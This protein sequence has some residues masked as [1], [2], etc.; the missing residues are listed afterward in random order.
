M[1]VHKE[2]HYFGSDLASPYRVDAKEYLQCFGTWR[3][4]KIAGETSV[5]Y[6]SSTEAA[7]EIRNFNPDG[8]VIIMLR[9]PV[10]AIH[11]L[12]HQVKFNRN[13]TIESLEAALAAEPDRA[14]GVDIPAGTT[15]VH[16]LLY[17]KTVS[18]AGQV[19][20]YLDVFGPDRVHVILYDD[21][22]RDTLT[23]YGRALDFLGVDPSFSPS[24]SIVNASKI[25]RSGTIQAALNHPPP[26]LVNSLRRIVPATFL[27]SSATMIARLNAKASA[28]PPMTP[29][30]RCRLIGELAPEIDQLGALIGRD[31]GMWKVPPGGDAARGQPGPEP[32]QEGK[33]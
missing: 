19:R 10:D 11:S 21:F 24:V 2:I 16:Q 8:R 17:R 14:R 33:R 1:P 22:L 3:D 15:K 29:E 5:Y 4:E 23:T 25:Y 32:I 31:L 18:Y 27:R 28:K 20:R 6:L 12:Y 13:E 26:W 30:L 7:R 9:N